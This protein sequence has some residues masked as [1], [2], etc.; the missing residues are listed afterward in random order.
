MV[1]WVLKHIERVF[2]RCVTIIPLFCKQH[3]ANLKELVLTAGQLV[4]H[5]IMF[6]LLINL[7]NNVIFYV[8]AKYT[9]LYRYKPS[10]V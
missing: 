9:T 6:F 8:K 5:Y 4:W 1:H 10:T 7:N 3:L 2:G